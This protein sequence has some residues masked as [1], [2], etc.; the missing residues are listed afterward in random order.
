MQ[1]SK[2]QI[3]RSYAYEAQ[4][5]RAIAE[6]IENPTEIVELEVNGRLGRIGSWNY[7]GIKEVIENLK[8]PVDISEKKVSTDGSPPRH[9]SSGKLFFKSVQERTFQDD[10]GNYYTTRY[11]GLR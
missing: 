8:L 2:Y 3:P 9:S 5:L 10:Q 4:V 11:K 6:A 1:R 7:S